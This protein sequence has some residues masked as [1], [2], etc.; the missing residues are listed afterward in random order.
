MQGKIVGIF[1]F[2]VLTGCSRTAQDVL[3]DTAASMGAGQLQTIRYSGNGFSFAIGQS[4]HPQ[5]PW[6]KFNTTSYT[7]TL[8]YETASLREETVQTQF[9]IPPRGGGRQPIVGERR[10]VSMVS[11]NYA[12][13]VAGE[14]A[15]PAPGVAEER[16]LEIW[17]TPH[18]VIKAALQNN[19]VLE[20]S[21][22]G[23][24]TV[25]SFQV[26]GKFPVKATIN[27][28]NLV[29]KVE[30][31]IANPVLG[32]MA[33][34]ISYSDYQDHQGVKFPARIVQR[35]GEHPSL[36]ITVSSV[37]ANPGLEV[38]IP[39]NVRTARIAPVRVESQEIANGVW[40]VAGGSH[41]S[42]AVE[43]QDH[44]VIVEGPQN[45]ERS[46]AVIAEVKNRIPGKPIRYVVNTHH[47]FD[48]SGGLRT[49]V[50]EGATIVTHE[51]NQPFYD[52]T[53]RAT[54]TL[55]SDKL[56]QS[57][58]PPKFQTVADKHVLSDST[59]TL[60]IHLMQGSGHNGGILMAY[61]PTERL[62][63]EADAFSPNQ[64][65]LPPPAEVDLLAINLLENIERLGLRVDRIL[66]I[67]GQVAPMADLRRA[68][69]KSS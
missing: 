58:V 66:P 43:F 30:T 7:R 47:H 56:S 11:G 21:S 3:N 20:P 45:E 67:H 50:A 53:F 15:V 9:E 10:Q 33:V 59:R 1:A 5:E 24:T 68:A 51:I 14:E 26:G 65:G 29:E 64:P 54:H 34:E 22:G 32:D 40:F 46:E 41:H 49:Y 17:L 63:I 2:L 37:E 44:V 35:T 4:F 19:A 55:R 48:H 60:E 27:A 6:P 28:Q 23:N 61:L 25:V 36:E 38:E 31:K 8:N 16:G 57:L 39:E 18:G 52:Q 13:S 69:R 62:L 42:V 12:W